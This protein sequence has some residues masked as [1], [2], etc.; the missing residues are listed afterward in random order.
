MCH[1]AHGRRKP[2]ALSNMPTSKLTPPQRGDCNLV[3]QCHLSAYQN[4]Q[5]QE[6]RW[7]RL[8]EIMQNVPPKKLCDVLLR[9]FLLGIQPLM[10]L[11]HVPSLRARYGAFWAQYDNTLRSS[12]SPFGGDDG[13]P[14][15]PLNLKPN[16]S[17]LCLFWAVLLCGAVAA[18]P[19]LLAE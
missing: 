16:P 10:P 14:A 15:G 7:S 2:P 3:L 19:A 18:S 11:V 13:R 9:S 5:F 6:H 1:L 8:S 12:L 4:R 17:F